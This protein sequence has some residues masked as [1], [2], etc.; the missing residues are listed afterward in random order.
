VLVTANPVRPAIRVATSDLPAPVIAGAD[1]RAIPAVI[2]ARTCTDVLAARVD[3]L[4]I[5]QH[6]RTHAIRHGF[7]EDVAR[8]AA[9]LRAEREHLVFGARPAVIEPT[10]GADRRVGSEDRRSRRDD[11]KLVVLV[12]G[13]RILVPMLSPSIVDPKVDCAST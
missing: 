1:A 6:V 4:R 7:V 12:D 11:R 5:R 2:A 9:V 10:N 3:E 13:R 8:R